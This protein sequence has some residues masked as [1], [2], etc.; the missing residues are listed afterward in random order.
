MKKYSYY[1]I[2]EIPLVFI[3]IWYNLNLYNFNKKMNVWLEKDSISLIIRSFKMFTFEDGK[4][5]NYL[6]GAI[7]IILFS[8]L[9]I[10]SNMIRNFKYD[11][12]EL[13]TVNII[14]TLANMII[15]FFTVLLMNNLVLWGFLIL[16]GFGSY[17][18]FVLGI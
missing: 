4:A 13:L 6:Y 1:L 2:F 5:F 18:S 15:I 17:I 11:T 7:L 3:S 16:C 14:C 8:S 10:A 9:I 12:D